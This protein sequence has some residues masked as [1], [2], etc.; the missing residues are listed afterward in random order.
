MLLRGVILQQTRNGEL[1]QCHTSIPSEFAKVGNMI[2]L[3]Y[4]RYF[5]IPV[6]D[7]WK[8]VMIGHQDE[9]SKYRVWWTDVVGRDRGTY[10]LL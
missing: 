1:F 7:P 4:N 6:T 9:N 8:V 2:H 5:P 10:A 3:V